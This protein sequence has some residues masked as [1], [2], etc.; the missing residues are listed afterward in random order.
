MYRGK[1]ARLSFVSVHIAKLLIYIDRRFSLFSVQLLY[2]QNK[3]YRK[4]YKL[5][6]LHGATAPRFDRT[7]LGCC[8]ATKAPYVSE[9]LHTC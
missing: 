6:F 2:T 1:R 5:A 9:R 8:G 3:K 7:R 4:L